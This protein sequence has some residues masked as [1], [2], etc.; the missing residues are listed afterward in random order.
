MLTPEA[1]QALMD[2]ARRYQFLKARFIAADFDWGEPSTSVLIF[3]WK[4]RVSADLDRTIDEAMT[5]TPRGDQPP[6]I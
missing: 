4:E 2:D 6:M 5:A 1:L 3:E